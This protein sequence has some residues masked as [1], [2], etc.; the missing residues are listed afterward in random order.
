MNEQLGA[1]QGRVRIYEVVRPERTLFERKNII[2]NSSAFLNARLLLN[3]VEPM[4][5][6]WGLAVGAGGLGGAWSASQQ[7]APTAL[8]VGMVSELKRK[9]AST[10][11][12]VDE[13]GN[14]TAT[15][16]TSILARTI[17]NATTDNITI[18]LREMGL[19][20]GGTTLSGNGG[21][22][23][24]LTAPYFDPSNPAANTVCLIN[25]LTIPSFPL[26]PNSD[27]AIDWTINCGA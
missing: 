14:P 17:L 4:F 15:I 3:S 18:A 10:I 22:T 13:N 16:T 27:M 7:P 19:I 9:Q 1:M 21:P 8:Q 11:F 23:N 6:I 20:G 12:F 5:G 25:Y 24:L 26:P 2:V